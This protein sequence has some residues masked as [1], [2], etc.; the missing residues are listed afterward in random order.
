MRKFLIT[1]SCFDFLFDD[2][3]GIDVFLN[4][5]KLLKSCFFLE[6]LRGAKNECAV[7]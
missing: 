2:V 7:I 1:S 3:Q 4:T 6:F 5:L